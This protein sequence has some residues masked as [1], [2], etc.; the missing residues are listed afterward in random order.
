MELDEGFFE[1]VYTDKSAEERKGEKKKLGRG[2]QKQS[3][4]M[5]MASTVHDFNPPKKQMKPTKF[6]YVRM[7]VMDKFQCFNVSMLHVVLGDG[8]LAKENE[9]PRSASG[10]TGLAM[11]QKQRIYIQLFRKPFAFYE[12]I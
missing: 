6:R 1:S 11:S 10:G 9:K 3:A 5:V 12:T 8:K 2:S 4:V 7:A